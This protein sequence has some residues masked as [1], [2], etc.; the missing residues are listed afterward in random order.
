MHTLTRLRRSGAAT[1][2]TVAAA[3]ALTSVP[4][5]ADAATALPTG[6]PLS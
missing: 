4:T 1:L 5:P 3:A 6:F 2:V